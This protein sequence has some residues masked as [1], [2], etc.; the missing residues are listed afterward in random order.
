MTSTAAKT[1]TPRARKVKSEDSPAYVVS[2]K[3]ERFTP[4]ELDIIAQ[5][6][7]L[8]AR[9]VS[10][11]LRMSDPKECS[12]YIDGLMRGRDRETFAAL[13]LDV[14][15]RVIAFEE[16]FHGSIDGCEVHPG[17]VVKRALANNA[18]AVIFTHNHPSGDS[19]P[20]AADRAVTTRLKQALAL[21]DIRCLDHFIVGDGAPRS[22]AALGMV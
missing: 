2:S 4:E 10:R 20:S 3:T 16:M 8:L 11:G 17:I 7:A 12:R 14:R 6:D 15:H 21:V 5:A 13:F 1:T 22:M 9:E 18:A 19:T